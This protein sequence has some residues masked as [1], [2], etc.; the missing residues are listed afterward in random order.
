MCKV[1]R[2]IQPAKGPI[3]RHA[4]SKRTA[5]GWQTHRKLPRHPK[6]KR[7]ASQNLSRPSSGCAKRPRSGAGGS[8]AQPRRTHRAHAA[9]TRRPRGGAG[10]KVG[11]PRLIHLAHAAHAKRPRGGAS[12][13][14]AKPR[15]THPARGAPP[16]RPR[17]G[18][19]GNAAKL[20]GPTQRT[21]RPRGAREAPTRRHW[22]QHGG[23]SAELPSARITL[24][25]RARR[26][27]RQRGETSA[28]SPN[29]LAR[30]VRSPRCKHCFGCQTRRGICRRL[31][32]PKHRIMM[33]LLHRAFSG[34]SVRRLWRP[35]KNR[36][37]PLPASMRRNFGEGMPSVARATAA[38]RQALLGHA[39]TYMGTCIRELMAQDCWNEPATSPVRST[40]FGCAGQIQKET[41]NIE[42][43]QGPRR[44]KYTPPSRGGNLCQT[45]PVPEPKSNAR[46]R[47]GPLRPGRPVQ[48][49]RRSV[50]ICFNRS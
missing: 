27:G 10:G 14:A 33:I 45:P 28:G 13:N 6:Q 23:T 39:A 3:A 35:A 17:G 16:R 8:A 1:A 2:S 49:Q 5:V 4:A 11:K 15:R 26:H 37:S 12:G 32:D 36:I 43:N 41:A 7:P 21:G 9:P 25:A 48:M 44:L 40:T 30:Y 20:G 19:G 18:A 22:R 42:T 38:R 29:S 24:E 31:A 47:W 46:A 34:C 50:S